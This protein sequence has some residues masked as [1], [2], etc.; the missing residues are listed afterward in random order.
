MSMGGDASNLLLQ[1]AEELDR[2][3]R[4]KIEKLLDQMDLARLEDDRRVMDMEGY[5]DL[6]GDGKRRSRKQKESL[7]YGDE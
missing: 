2:Q 3:E 6:A 4:I 7:T 5:A 1:E